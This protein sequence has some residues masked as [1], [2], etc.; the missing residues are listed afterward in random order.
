MGRSL[1]NCRDA[2][3]TRPW[4]VPSW[5]IHSQRKDKQVQR[6]L[7]PLLYNGAIA[8]RYWEELTKG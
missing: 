6:Q 7:I 5:S 1:P 8:N 3:E 4:I 2:R